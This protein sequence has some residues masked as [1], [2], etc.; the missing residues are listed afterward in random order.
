MNWR[1]Q[2]EETIKN[3]KTKNFV[4]AGTH[5]R[6][7]EKKIAEN[8][9]RTKLWYKSYDCPKVPKKNETIIII[10]IGIAIIENTKLLDY[11]LKKV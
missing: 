11:L 5:V 7:I 6:K 1:I 10:E 4:F 9:K 3:S 2:H 8:K